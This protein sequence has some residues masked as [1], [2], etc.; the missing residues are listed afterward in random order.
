MTVFPE[1]TITPK[2]LPVPPTCKAMQT[3][4]GFTLIEVLITMVVIALGLLGLAG[5]QATNLKNNQSAYFRSQATQLA[6]DIADR[7]RVNNKNLAADYNEQMGS[8]LDEDD[9]VAKKAC[10]ENCETNACSTA[11]MA[12]YDLSNWAVNMAQTLPSGV[13]IV[14]KDSDPEDGNS[15]GAHNC[16]GLGEAYAVKIWW[17]DNRDGAANQQ[18]VMSFQPNE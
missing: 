16:D 3:C 17:D 11:E 6:Y 2:L 5:L 1:M 9:A 7:M 12:D 15:P 13:G 10:L 14:C 18:F 4:R 8:C